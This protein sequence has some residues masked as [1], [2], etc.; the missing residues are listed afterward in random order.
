[1]M[2]PFHFLWIIVIYAIFE[3]CNH[4]KIEDWKTYVTVKLILGFGRLYMLDIFYAEIF[5]K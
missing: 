3:Y 2:G 1:M 4:N 5:S